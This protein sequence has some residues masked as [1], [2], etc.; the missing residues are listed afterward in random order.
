MS[1]AFVSGL[2]PHLGKCFENVKQLFI[3]KQEVGPPAV[4]MLISAEGETLVLPKYDIC[5]IN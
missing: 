1:L 4:L 5:V 2:Q 3:G